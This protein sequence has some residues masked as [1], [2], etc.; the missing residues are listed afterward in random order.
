LP[1]GEVFRVLQDSG[2]IDDSLTISEFEAQ[3]NNLK[4]FPNQPDVEA[5]HEGYPDAQARTQDQKSR[6][7]EAM[8]EREAEMAREHQKLIDKR[9]ADQ[10]SDLQEEAFDQGLT[11]IQWQAEQDAKLAKQQAA[12][13]AKAAKEQAKHDI[14]VGKATKPAVA[15]RPKPAAAKPAAG[16]VSKVK[17]K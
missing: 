6:R 17:T 1:I 16:K 9:K 3:L 2:F 11:T 10:Q 15:P 13:D 7:Q 8:T 14:K 4:N 5:M 12:H